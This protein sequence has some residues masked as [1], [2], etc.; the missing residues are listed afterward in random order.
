MGAC[1]DVDKLY[2]ETGLVGEAKEEIVLLREQRNQEQ[3]GTS[4]IPPCPYHRAGYGC[5]L[6]DLKSPLCIAHF[7]ADWEWKRNFGVDAQA[8]KSEIETTLK[9]I[10]EGE[11]LES[12]TLVERFT[13]KV[14]SITNQI[15]K[16][17][18]LD[19]SQKS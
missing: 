12:H 19:G 2:S 7:D 14:T 13:Q 10:L 16:H 5:V 11:T 9:L 18:I 15:V 8:L 17:P 6:E 1:K 4:T 3:G